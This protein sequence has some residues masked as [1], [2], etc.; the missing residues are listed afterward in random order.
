MDDNQN[1][2]YNNPLITYINRVCIYFY[3][4]TSPICAHIIF[5][6]VLVYIIIFL[7]QRYSLFQNCTFF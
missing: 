1:V 3:F 6:S 4:C 7:I 2:W 5:S